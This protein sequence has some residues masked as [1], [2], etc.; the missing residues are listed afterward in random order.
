MFVFNVMGFKFKATLF[1]IQ[2]KIHQICR[3]VYKL[4]V[5][6]SV[7]FISMDFNLGA[8]VIT[9]ADFIEWITRSNILFHWMLPKASKKT[10]TWR[11]ILQTFNF[12][13]INSWYAC[14]L[15]SDQTF[16]YVVFISNCWSFEYWPLNLPQIRS[17]N[18]SQT[19]FRQQILHF[20]SFNK[21]SKF[22]FCEYIV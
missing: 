6:K 5:Y 17:V 12:G 14:Y 20:V 3:N 7:V 13:A 11:S 18:I 10:N 22:A 2:V 4:R 16:Q 19:K 15:L 21:T 9:S 1:F 8:I